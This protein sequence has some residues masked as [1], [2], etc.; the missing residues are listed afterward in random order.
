MSQT[1]HILHTSPVGAGVGDAK[2]TVPATSAAPKPDASTGLY[3][4]QPAMLGF[5]GFLLGSLSL[6]FYLKDVSIP[7]NS[8]SP[9]CRSWCSAA[10]SCC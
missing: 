10:P 6:A 8:W 3:A 5:A 2:A 7:A 4:P 9:S 1:E